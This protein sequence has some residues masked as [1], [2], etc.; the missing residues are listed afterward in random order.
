M[1]KPDIGS[2]HDIADQTELPAE[3]SNSIKTPFDAFWNI[4]SDDLLVIITIQT[5]IYVH[6]RK[7]L[8]PPA[9]TEEVKVV[10]SILLLSGYFR[11]P[12]RELYCSTPPDTH[13]E[14]V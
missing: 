8:N 6:Q 9:T 10:I 4:Y 7:G 2:A 14:S 5:N 13:N 1:E 3:L 12:Y 11:V